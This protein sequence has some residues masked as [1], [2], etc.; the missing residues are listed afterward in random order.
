MKIILGAI[1]PGNLLSDSKLPKGNQLMP[2]DGVH[3]DAFEPFL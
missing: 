2:N 1:T 3:A